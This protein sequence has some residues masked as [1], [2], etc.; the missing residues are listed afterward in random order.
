[1]D[2]EGYPT[3]LRSCVGKP[4]PVDCKWGPFKPSSECSKICGGRL[5]NFTRNIIQEANHGGTECIGDATKQES[6]NEG[7]CTPPT[8][9][10]EA[11]EG[12]LNRLPGTFTLQIDSENT[13]K[14]FCDADGYTYLMSRGQFQNPKD[15]FNK[16]W[17]GYKTAFGETNKEY[18]IGLD[19]MNK[20]TNRGD[21]P[22][23][24]RVKI[25]KFS[26]EKAINYYDTFKIGNEASNYTL[27]V[28]GFHGDGD[29]LEYH[30]G[31][32]FSTIDRD[33]DP[34][35]YNCASKSE[36]GA[37]AGWWYKGCI[38]SNLNG[39]NHGYAKPAQE[40]MSWSVWSSGNKY[41]SLK[42]ASM[43]IRPLNV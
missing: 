38:F 27:T 5:K 34:W 24:L 42:S 4:C 11:K 41:E 23:Q 43:A 17:N 12:G 30:N 10:Y 35:Y 2:C 36:P 15:Y 7:T 37:G 9:C 20:L 13:I 3:E 28:G 16:N 29:A 39:L 14:A 33:N 31:M 26:G 40:S 8:D 19:M 21:R 25:E 18:W 22:M 32:A 1:L 6:C